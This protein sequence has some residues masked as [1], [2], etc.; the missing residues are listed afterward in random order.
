MQ[1]SNSAAQTPQKAKEPT[2]KHKQNNIVYAARTSL[3]YTDETQGM[4]N[5]QEDKC[6]FSACHWLRT[7]V[8][9]T[10][11]TKQ[12]QVQLPWTTTARYLST[13]ALWPWVVVM[14]M[15]VESMLPN[16]LLCWTVCSLDLPHLPPVQSGVT[17]II[18][19]K[20]IQHD[21]NLIFKPAVSANAWATSPLGCLIGYLRWK[22]ITCE[23]RR[24][25]K[26]W[27]YYAVIFSWVLLFSSAPLGKLAANVV[28]RRTAAKIWKVLSQQILTQKVDSGSCSHMRLTQKCFGTFPG[29]SACRKGTSITVSEQMFGVKVCLHHTSSSAA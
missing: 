29:Q 1:L 15:D 21:L 24:F 2:P 12:Q 3:I 20:S 8:V 6:W 9:K 28:P 25:D 4:D 27:L 17:D 11:W 16:H 22:L 14:F 23:L 19:I 18:H 13:L 5:Y 7:G 26:V 10:A